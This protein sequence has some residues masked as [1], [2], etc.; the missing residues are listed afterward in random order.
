MPNQSRDGNGAVEVV[1]SFIP[2]QP[3]V[4]TRGFDLAAPV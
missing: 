4:D 1:L 3:L 2:L